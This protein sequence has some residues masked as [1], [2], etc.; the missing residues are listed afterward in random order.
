[1]ALTTVV[2]ST[3]NRREFL[4]EAVESVRRQ[5][6]EE[7]ELIVV[8]DAS[9][10]DSWAWLEAQ[11]DERV[12]ALRHTVNLERSAAR[13]RGLQE[14]RGE[15]VMFLDDDDRLRP[16]ALRLLTSAMAQRAEAV[17]AVGGRW[18]FR[19]GVYGVAIPHAPVG[20]CKVIWP[21]LLAGWSAV[22]GQNL[23]RT[24]VVRKIGGFREDVLVVEDRRLWLSVA[25]EG[26]VAVVPQTT[27][28]YRDHGDSRRPPDIVARRDAVYQ[29]FL[30]ELSGADLEKGQRVRRAG[31]LADAEQF[32]AAMR[33]APELAVSPLTGPLWA[34]GLAKA[35]LAPVWKPRQL[36]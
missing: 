9:T 10:D 27:L 35:L 12:R 17:A 14:A 7:W 15:F 3:Y 25:R 19:T 1:M 23:Y 6:A 16:E 18:K 31:R 33:T 5:T 30:G 34:R 8:D 36:G 11:Q 22:S 2:I 20:A 32:F 4:A 28:E 29:E 13:N 24:E 26:P 21:E